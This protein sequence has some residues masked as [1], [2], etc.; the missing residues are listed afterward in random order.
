MSWKDD[1]VCLEH[2]M[3][4][5]LDDYWTKDIIGPPGETVAK[6]KELCWTCPVRNQ[7]LEEALINEEP[8]WI[9]GGFTPRERRSLGRAITDPEGELIILRR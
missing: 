6:A 8:L 7:C 4:K 9:Y 1:A 5:K 2:V 3:V